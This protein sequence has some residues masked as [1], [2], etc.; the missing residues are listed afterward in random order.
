[1]HITAEALCECLGIRKGTRQPIIRLAERLY[2]PCKQVTLTGTCCTL[3]IC[4]QTIFVG[5]FEVLSSLQMWFK[6]MNESND[7]EQ[8]AFHKAV[9]GGLKNAAAA[10]GPPSKLCKYGRHPEGLPPHNDHMHLNALLQVLM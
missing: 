4:G 5:L 10:G 6:A 2:S 7:M 9:S 1:M 8:L 3:C